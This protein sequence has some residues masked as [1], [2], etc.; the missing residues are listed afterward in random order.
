M[1][2]KNKPWKNKMNKGS[3][4]N[5][6]WDEQEEKKKKKTLEDWNTNGQNN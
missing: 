5:K 2:Q 1:S 4:F 6:Y 3:D